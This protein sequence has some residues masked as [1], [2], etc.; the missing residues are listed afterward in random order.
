MNREY[1]LVNQYH[2]ACPRQSDE[3]QTTEESGEPINDQS[4]NNEAQ[5]PNFESDDDFPVGD[6]APPD[7]DDDIPA[8]FPDET[9]TG[10]TQTPMDADGLPRPGNI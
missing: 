9:F 4:D 1:D 8:H 5:Q 3:D 7:D 6:F 10:D 2:D